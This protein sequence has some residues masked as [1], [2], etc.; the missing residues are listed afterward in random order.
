MSVELSSHFK[1]REPSVI[2]EAQIIFSERKDK[3]LIKVVNMAIGNIHLPMH[4]VLQKRMKELGE[5]RFSNGVVKY[6]PSAG[7]KEARDAFLNIIAAS[8]GDISSLNC[9]I[10]DGGSQAM[11]LMM[12]GVCG[13]SSKRPLIL[14]DPAYT[15]Y[16]E[17]GKR[18]SIPI[19]S[20]DRDIKDDG[21]FEEIDFSNL[22]S[23]IKKNNPSG[24][25][26]IPYDNPTGQFLSQNQ[27]IKIA[28]LCVQYKLWI[29]SDEAYRPLFYGSGKSSSIWKITKDMVPGIEGIRISIE[30]ASKVWNACGLRIGSL[31][32]DNK[33]FYT[34]SVS[35]YTANLCANALGQEIFAGLA[36]ETHEELIKWFQLQKDYYKSTMEI[37]RNNFLKEIPGLIVT[38]PEAAIYFIIDF[39][40]ICD[41]SFNAA[42]F[43]RY[44]ASS[45]KVEIDGN[46]FTLLLA[47]MQGFYRNENSGKT[48]LRVAI[49]ESKDLMEKAPKILSKLY[50]SYL[51]L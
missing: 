22:E 3:D 29:I 34:K 28:K 13:P 23:L 5:L 46:L 42:A 48:Q 11:E 49:V 2:R 39:R 16:L 36:Q 37:L 4:P 15:N 12:L 20:L 8:G 40:N 27:L 33:G 45:G 19:I 9:M 26:V 41:D 51:K 38:N 1:S 14:L 30:S 43:I 44:C 10:T 18:L 47:P 21:G 25:L 7:T 32:T 24:L 35:E 50:D 17:F 6:T 31:V